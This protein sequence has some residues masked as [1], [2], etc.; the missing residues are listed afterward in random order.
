MVG[1]S[2]FRSPSPICLNHNFHGN[3]RQKWR[4]L[5]TLHPLT[6]P[7]FESIHFFTYTKMDIGY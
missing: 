4:I 5:T 3:A 2:W 7:V 1:R 6:N